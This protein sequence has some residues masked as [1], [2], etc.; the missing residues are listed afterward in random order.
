MDGHDDGA[1]YQR[2]VSFV[3]TEADARDELKKYFVQDIKDF[4][5]G[6]LDAL[7]PEGLQWR[8]E[9]QTFKR[10]GRSGA[11]VMTTRTK[12]QRLVDMRESELGHVAREIRSWPADVGRHKGRDVWQRAVLGYIENFPTAHDDA[13]VVEAGELTEAEYSD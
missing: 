1:C 6:N 8:V 9:R 7:R 4:F 3:Q 5:G 12:L 11:I 10:L 2:Q 13:T